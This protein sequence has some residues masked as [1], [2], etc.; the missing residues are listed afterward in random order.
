MWL[1]QLKAGL[2]EDGRLMTWQHRIVGQSILAGTVLEDSRVK[3]G[4]DHTSVEGAA[5][6]PYDVPNRL[7]DLHSP[8][9]D[10]PVLWWRSV[11]YSHNAFVVEGFVDELAHAAGRDAIDF[12]L[13]MLAAHPRHRAVLELAAE[14]AGWGKSPPAGRSRGVALCKSFGSIVAEVAEVSVTDEG[15]IKVHRVTCAVDCGFAL[16]PLN[17]AA[18]MEG[19]IA[20]GLTAALYGELVFEDGR[21]QQSNFH[22]YP[23]LRMNEMPEVEVHIL[24]RQDEPTGVGEP[25][26]P[27]IAP[28]L[29]TPSSPRPASGFVPSRSPSTGFIRFDDAGN[30]RTAVRI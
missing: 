8:A 7:V 30:R 6:L 15:G 3:D 16:N 2:D 12:R 4:I 17:V 29:A 5:H 21:V 20:F 26:T 11:G 28:A 13:Q 23:M 19:G 10:I 24:P 1:S 25:G 27:P 18:Q 14:K 9:L 22:D